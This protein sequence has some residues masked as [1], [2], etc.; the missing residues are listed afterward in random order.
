LGNPVEL[1]LTPGQAHDLACAEP[2]IDN[3]DPQALIGDKGYDA[4]R[5]VEILAE[6][7]IT[8]VIP[9]TANRKVTRPCDYVLL[10]A[11]PHRTLLQSTQALPRHRNPV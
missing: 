10:R 7:R 9:P 6:R 3:A 1:M 5:F 4:D 8:P 2:L 11:Q